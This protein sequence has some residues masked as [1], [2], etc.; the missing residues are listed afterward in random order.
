MN[1][2][3]RIVLVGTTHPGNIGAAARAM[4][5]M[6]LGSLHLVDPAGFPSAEATAMASGADDLLARAVVHEMLPDAIADCR[7]VLGTS[8]RP[9]TLDWS[10][11]GPE[12][13]ARLAVEESSRHPVAM[14]FGRERYGLTN[15]EVKCCQHLVQI[16]ANPEYSSLNLAQAVQVICYELARQGTVASPSRVEREPVSAE[17]LEGYFGHLE[18]TLRQIGFLKDQSDKLM[19]RLRRLYHRARPDATEI[20]ILRGILSDTQRIAARLAEDDQS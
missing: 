15:D 4:K 2:N 8:A 12:D 18:E 9:R 16:P 10:T 11:L 7:L 14:L 5:T 19:L 17:I 20:N 1:E 6:G 3:I 13:A